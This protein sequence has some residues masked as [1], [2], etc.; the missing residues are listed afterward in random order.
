MS[1]RYVCVCIPNNPSWSKEA[2]L[3]PGST[4]EA[5]VGDG[6]PATLRSHPRQQCFL[7]SSSYDIQSRRYNIGPVERYAKIQNTFCSTRN[8]HQ[9]SVEWTLGGLDTEIAEAEAFAAQQLRL[10]AD[11]AVEES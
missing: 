1:P 2:L 8:L 5:S 11:A 7:S 4:A 10:Q 6:M 3:R 9:S